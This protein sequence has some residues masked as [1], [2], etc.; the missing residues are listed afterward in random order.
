MEVITLRTRNIVIFL[1]VLLMAAPLICISGEAA[2]PVLL[3]VPARYTIIKLSFDISALRNVQ[4]VSYSGSAMN[5]D[6]LLNLWNGDTREWG[7]IGVKEYGEGNF[8][9]V[10]PGMVVLIGAEADLPFPL[11]EASSW[12]QD[13][14]RIQTLD[15]V[16]ILN[17]LNESMKFTSGEWKWFAGRYDLVLKDLNAGR[18]QGYTKFE[19]YRPGGKPAEESKPFEGG[20]EVQAPP[21]SVETPATT[22]SVPGIEGEPAVIPVE[23]GEATIIDLDMSAPEEPAVAVEKPKTAD[24]PP[25]QK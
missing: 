18:R 17:T 7:K 16:T 23:G 6:P 15:I 3:V 10:P 20:A 25:E 14:K 2:S 19:K 21:V 13:V 8:S 11:I 4:I 12:C 5:T 22:P 9:G 24:I 1:L